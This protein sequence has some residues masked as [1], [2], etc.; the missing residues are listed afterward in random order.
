MDIKNI[1]IYGLNVEDSKRDI[2]ITAENIPKRN[3]LFTPM[4][5]MICGKVISAMMPITEE[6]LITNPILNASSN[7]P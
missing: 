7:T 1:T 6:K 2:K 3:I 4:F 5:L